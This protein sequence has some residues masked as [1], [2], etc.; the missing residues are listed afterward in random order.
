MRRHN[1]VGAHPV[2]LPTGQ[3][4]RPVLRPD[5]GR[6]TASPLQKIKYWLLTGIK[7]LMILTAAWITIVAIYGLCV[8]Y[9]GH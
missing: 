8:I 2:G 5:T 4:G 1:L 7:A 6:V 3:A 9:G